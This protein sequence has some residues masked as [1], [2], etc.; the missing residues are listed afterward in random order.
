MFLDLMLKTSKAIHGLFAQEMR[1]TFDQIP[2]E[3]Q[4]V[5]LKKRINWIL[6]G[7]ST[8]AKP[9]RAWG[10]PTQVMIE[11]TTHCNLRCALCPVTTGMN[12][13]TGHMD[14]K[15]F[16]KVI[17]EI[18]DYVLF[19]MLWNWG[20]PFLNPS[21]YDMISYAKERNI[22]VMSSTNG[23]PFARGDHPDRLVRSGIDALIFALDGISQETYE[24][25]RKG[26]MIETVIAGIK[27]VV[28]AKKALNSRT[29]YIDLRFMVMKHNEHEIPKL[30]DFT[31]SLG[32]DGLTLKTMNPYDRS[33]TKE[34]GNDFLPENPHYQRFNYDPKTHLPIRRKQNPCKSLWDS[35]VINWDGKVSPCCFD[36]H[37]QYVLGDLTRNTFRDIWLGASYREFRRKFRRDCQKVAPCSKCT[38]AFEGGSFVDSIVESHLVGPP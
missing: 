26:G 1:M 6:A 22:K 8:L 19:I 29:P 27:N 9:E 31:K 15:I 24:R 28:A 34:D 36:P 35:P 4:R 38:H 25:Y 5:S 10:W 13:P 20:E 32:V 17:D 14:F 3:F 23:H 30:K 18:E 33:L 12:R 11:P 2:F 16:K 7:A 21:I 37:N